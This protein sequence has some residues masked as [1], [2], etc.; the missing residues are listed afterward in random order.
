M[1]NGLLFTNG[2]IFDLIE[3][4]SGTALTHK[5]TFSGLMVPMMWNQMKM[6]VPIML[7]SMN[8]ALKEKAEKTSD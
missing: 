1:M 2:K 5:E 7:N 8:L 6:G 3:T 4:E